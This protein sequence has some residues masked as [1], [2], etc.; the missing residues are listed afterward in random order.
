MTERLRNLGIDKNNLDEELVHQVQAF[1]EVADEYVLA[2]SN[3]DSAKEILAEIDAGLDH[4]YRQGEKK[5][6][7]QIKNLILLDPEHGQAYANYTNAKL[8]A[9]RLSAL[10]DAYYQ[11]NEAL[12]ELCKLY[13]AGYWSTTS[14]KETSDVAYTQRRKKLAE[15]RKVRVG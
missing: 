14:V 6:E 7:A 2:V 15:A 8:T 11:R 13:V 12:K 4:K 10:K 9:A 1:L 3:A 5:T